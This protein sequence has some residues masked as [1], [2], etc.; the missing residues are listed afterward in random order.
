[1][2]EEKPKGQMHVPEWMY[3][4]AIVLM[5]GLIA[6]VSFQTHTEDFEFW[7][8]G[9]ITELKQENRELRANVQGNTTNIATINSHLSGIER[10]VADIK[11][12]VS[13]LVRGRMAKME[14]R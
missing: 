9:E 2:A 6:F 5:G 8:R 7:A 14:E 11:K 12:D 13:Y 4:L 3:H 10:D 1:M